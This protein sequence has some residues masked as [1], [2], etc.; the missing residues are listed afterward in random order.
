MVQLF[1]KFIS[2]QAQRLLYCAHVLSR[3]H[4]GLVIW[5]PMITQ[6]S[7]KSA[8]YKKVAF[9]IFNKPKSIH[10]DPLFRKS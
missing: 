3:I 7:K 8:K 6:A 2:I 5:G 9:F 10:T 4:Y 1:R